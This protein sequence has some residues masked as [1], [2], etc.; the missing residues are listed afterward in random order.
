[1]FSKTLSRTLCCLFVVTLACGT[2][3]AQG[4]KRAPKP[5]N[6]RFETAYVDKDS[7]RANITIFTNLGPTPSNLY[8]VIDGGYYVSGPLAIDNPVDQWIAMPFTN[9]IADH[10]TQIQAAIGYIS[11]TKKLV[12]GIYTDNA[13]SVGTLLV[14]GQT[15][16]VPA[17]GVCCQVATVNVA[18]TALNAATQYWVVAQEHPTAQDFEAVWQASNSSLIG[19]NVGQAGWFTFSGL[20]PA[21]AVKGTNP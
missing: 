14:Q 15:A 18:S 16:N 20:V 3:M 4:L 1:M 2:L 5:T 17:A 13:G 12:M 8:D 9:K 21:F 19:G 11:G 6:P 10:V 7:T